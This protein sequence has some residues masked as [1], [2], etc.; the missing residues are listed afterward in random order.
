MSRKILV[1]DDEAT[2]LDVVVKKLV[3][4]GFEVISALTGKG[5]FDKAKIYLPDLILL[6][7]L[8]PDMEGPEVARLLQ[9]DESTKKIPII[10]LSGSLVR[11][12]TAR[13][14]SRS[15]IFLTGPLASLLRFVS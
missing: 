7:I 11:I 8:L 12:T 6:D 14:K 9:S 13:I 2:V 5:G 1:V 4:Q 3:E 15:V 10:F